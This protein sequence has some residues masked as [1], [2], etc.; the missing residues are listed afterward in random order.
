LRILLLSSE[1]IPE[2]A[3]GIATYTS[4]IAPALAARG[5]EVHVLSC[6]PEHDRRD[7]VVDGV[8]WHR[9]RLIAGAHPLD[10]DRGKQ[11]AIRLVTAITC[12]K[13]LR[14]LGGRFDVVESPEWLA[15]SLFISTTTRVPVVVNLHTPASVLFSFDPP[16][17]LRDV[18]YAGQIERFAA[19]RARRVTSTSRLLADELRSRGWLEKVDDII[20]IPVD[21]DGWPV[22]DVADTAPVILVVGRLEPRKAP[23]TVVEAAALLRSDIPDLRLV[24][25]GRS[26]GYLRG[27]KPYGEFVAD[28]AAELDIVPEFVS[29]IPYEE[30]RARYAS[31]R[32]VAV[33]SRFESF[34]MTA[35]EGMAAARPIVYS[36]R[37]GAAEVLRGTGGGTEVP[38]DDPRSLADALRPYLTDSAAAARAGALA[39]AAVVAQCHPAVIA[40][41][42]EGCYIAA[43]ERS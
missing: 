34:S 14:S 10:W 41:K 28:R 32:V 37:I 19:K 13:E 17:H 5:H 2:R 30:A 40:E 21:V 15:E 6:A 8:H 9:R 20:H 18:G 23:E 31:A 25:V 11:V 26:R 39:R 42:R 12:R 38:P 16:R 36:S 24:F 4:T 3:G 35:L 22:S 43:I 7:D 1:V 29:Q 33:P 27:G